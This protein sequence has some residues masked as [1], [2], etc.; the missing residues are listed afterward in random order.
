MH[1]LLDK[2]L[3]IEFLGH[4]DTEFQMLANE[5]LKTLGPLSLPLLLVHHIVVVLDDF[6]NRSPELLHHFGHVLSLLTDLM[7]NVLQLSL[8]LELL[9]MQFLLASS[10]ILFRV[11]YLLLGL[12]FKILSHPFHL[13]DKKVPVILCRRLLLL[14]TWEGANFIK[15]SFCL[16]ELVVSSCAY[17]FL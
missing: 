17:F 16:A 3:G 12:P 7:L 8:L 4:F 10:R 1:A 2:R 11:A 6:L 14:L 13:L 15:I 9:F 5:A